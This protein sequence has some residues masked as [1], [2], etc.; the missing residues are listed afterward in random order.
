[1]FSGTGKSFLIKTIR[2]VCQSY[3]INVVLT[4]TTNV[5]S[6]NIDGQTIHKF[7][8]I[9]LNTEP[10]IMIVNN[11]STYRQNAIRQVELL[12]IDEVSMMSIKLFEKINKVFRLVRDDCRPFGGIRLLLSGD[13][14]QLPIVRKNSIPVRTILDSDLWPKLNVSYTSM[15]MVIRQTDVDFVSALNEIRTCTENFLSDDTISII[16]SMIRLPDPDDF[17]IIYLSGLRS[18]CDTINNIMCKKIFNI[19]KQYTYDDVSLCCD[20]RVIFV[21]NVKKF[22]IPKGTIGIIVGFVKNKTAE[23]PDNRWPMLPVI[24]IPNRSDIVLNNDVMPLKPAFAITVHAAQGC[25]LDR[26]AL[27][28]YSLFEYQHFYTAISR[29]RTCDDVFILPKRMYVDCDLLPNH[30]ILNYIKF[31]VKFVNPHIKDCLSRYYETD[32]YKTGF[33][34]NN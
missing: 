1:M 23:N 17:K 16:R 20:M 7:T 10:A 2:N 30:Q 14:L 11:M 13:L 27:N 9:N 18:E 25:T 21:E 8:G 26:I 33:I 32:C 19:R 12:I 34:E 6:E 3:G 28:V 29:V 5:S 15:D 31:K 22:N 4:S 24:K